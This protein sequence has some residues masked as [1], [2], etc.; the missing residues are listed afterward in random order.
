MAGWPLLKTA[1]LASIWAEYR[2][3]APRNT[4]RLTV[5]MS[6]SVHMPWAIGPSHKLLCKLCTLRRY[7]TNCW[8]S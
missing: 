7:S 5:V 1:P 6:L 2:F 4:F 3:K 8:F